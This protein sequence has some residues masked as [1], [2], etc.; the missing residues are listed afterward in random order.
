MLHELQ[1]PTRMAAIVTLFVRSQ[2]V[3]YEQLLR[4]LVDMRAEVEPSL[5]L[6]LF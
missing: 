1:D 5:T 3:Q 4:P 2:Y 6:I